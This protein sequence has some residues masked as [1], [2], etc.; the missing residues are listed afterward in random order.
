V[1]YK[2]PEEFGGNFKIYS[3]ERSD[4]SMSRGEIASNL[5][6]FL[7][8][9]CASAQIAYSEQVHG[10]RIEIINNGGYY[11]NC[12]GLVTG[13]KIGL[14]VKSAD[15]IPLLFLEKEKG[16][17]GGIHVGW[18][19]LKKGIISKSLRGVFEKMS[20]SPASAMIF[21][22]PHIRKENYEVKN[23]LAEE[24]PDDLR[25]FVS[26]SSGKLYFDLT[27]AVKYELESV[28]AKA[29]NI[30]DSKVDTFD[31]S[32]LFSYRKG[33]KELFVT[34]IVKSNG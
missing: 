19:S 25:K 16:I 22:G 20:L 28:G 33:D 13:E 29:E 10:E 26:P 6:K 1:E 9:I 14:V 7:E 12:D 31:E 15:C 18:R 34:L 11:E 32:N 27:A 8:K 24:L 17:T 3:S 21:L 4:G 23:D 2:L 30:I 5:P